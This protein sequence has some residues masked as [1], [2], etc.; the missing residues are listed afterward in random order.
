MAAGFIVSIF[1]AS[2]YHLVT[3]PMLRRVRW[4]ITTMSLRP[5]RAMPRHLHRCLWCGKPTSVQII[6]LNAVQLGRRMKVILIGATGMIGSRVLRELLNR[7]HQISA[8]VRSPDKL[9][10]ESNL[11]VVI[12]DVFNE[13]LLV[14]S[15]KGHDAVIHAYKPPTDHPDRRGEHL[16]AI[17]SIVSAVRRAGLKR[18]LAI[19]GAGTLEVAPGIKYMETAEF[20]K[21]WM[22]GAISTAEVTNT[23]RQHPELDWTALSPPHL[24]RPGIRTGVFRLG[25]DQLMRDENNESRIS[26]EDY[27]VAMIDELENPRHIRRRFTLAY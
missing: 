7:G 9:Q 8:I 4:S 27:A 21:E 22:M 6:L 24:I 15:F 3:T 5:G 20:P 14:E 2:V 11:S 12:G 17:R 13:D 23:L 18:V 26:A 16:R 10:P 19:A 25:G 1:E